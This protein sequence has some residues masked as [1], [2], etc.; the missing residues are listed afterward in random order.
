M[1]SAVR[2]IS[3]LKI[4]GFLVPAEIKGDMAKSPRKHFWTHRESLRPTVP[5][6]RFPPQLE[7]TLSHWWK[8]GKD[9]VWTLREMT[10]SCFVCPSLLHRRKKEADVCSAPLFR[11]HPCPDICSEIPSRVHSSPGKQVSVSKSAIWGP[12]GQEDFTPGWYKWSLRWCPAS[13]EPHLK[14][15]V[16]ESAFT[17]ESHPSNRHRQN[18]QG[19][20]LTVHTYLIFS[21]KQIKSTPFCAYTA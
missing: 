2:L 10:R 17:V 11:R 9:L 7:V 3:L 18:V 6:L 4:T 16:P 20:S 8:R 13:S 19:V 14:L 5:L 21:W 15:A 12:L 1:N